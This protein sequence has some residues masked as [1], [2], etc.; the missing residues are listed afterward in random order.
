MSLTPKEQQLKVDLIKEELSLVKRLKQLDKQ[1][2]TGSKEFLKTAQQKNKVQADLNKLLGITQTGIKKIGKEEDDLLKKSKQLNSLFNGLDTSLDNVAKK[3][4]LAAS[5]QKAFAAFAKQTGQNYIKQKS[6]QE[7]ISTIENVKLNLT[8]Q[9][10]DAANTLLKSYNIEASILEES[11]QLTADIADEAQQLYKY[12]QKNSTTLAESLNTSYAKERLADMEVQFA[13]NKNKL[14]GKSLLMAQQ[15]INEARTKVGMLDEQSNALDYQ[16]SQRQAMHDALVG[17]FEA[18]KSTIES[19][20]GGQ[21]LSKAI[22]LDLFGD[23]LSEQLNLS[24]QTGL[25]EGAAAGVQRFKDLTAS[26]KVFGMSLKS[27]L[28]PLAAAGVLL[29]ALMLFKQMSAETEE[30]AANTGQSANQ[31][32]KMLQSARAMQASSA[33]NL[34]NTEEIVSAM[35]AMKEEFGSTANFS[36]ETAMNVANMSAAFGIAVGDAAA[37]QRQFEAMGQTS[38]EAF[39]TQALAANLSEAAGVA[40]G[41]VMKD[42]A[43]NSKRAAKYMGGNAKALTKAAIEAAR[44]GMELGDMVDIADG[45]LDI[46]SSIE[47]EFEASVMLGKQIN[48]DLARQL[49]LQGDIEGATKA[50]L[51]QVGSIHDFNKLDVLQRKKLAQAAGM[52]VGQLQDALQKQ[53]QMNSLTAEQKKR[54]DDASKAL[55]GGT[56][57]GEQLVKQQ[58]AALA[59]KEM[60]A[61][62]DKI[63]NTLMKALYPVIKAITQI[64]TNVLA[65]IL[66]VVGAIFSG[67]M[68]ALKPVLLVFQGIAKVVK[69]LSPALK[70]IAGIIG[71]IYAVKALIWAGDKA[72]LAIQ[73]T[74]Q[75]FSSKEQM[76]STATN[77]AKKMGLITDK[78]AVAQQKIASM[79]SKDYISDETMA[80]TLKNKGLLAKMK[81]NFQMGLITLKQKLGIGLSATEQGMLAT[82]LG[83]KGTEAQI[84]NQINASKNTGLMHTLKEI[85]YQAALAIK[86]GAVWTWEM[87]TNAEKRTAFLL[88]LKETVQ[89]GLLAIAKGAVWLWQTMTATAATATTAATG[90]GAAASAAAIAPT[91]ALA[92]T[93]AAAATAAMTTSSAASFG[94]GIA[95]ILAAVGIGVAA[96]FALMAGASAMMSDGVIGPSSGGSGGYGSRVLFG[97]EGAISFNN[98]DTIVAGTDL[99]KAND[100]AFGP[101]GSMSMADSGPQEIELK[102]IQKDAARKLLKIQMIGSSPM[103]ML[104]GGLG[105]MGGALGSMFGGGEDGES[106]EGSPV[107]D[108]TNATKLDALAAKLDAVITAIAGTGGSGGAQGPVQIVIGNKVIEEISGMMNVNKSY[109]IGAGNAGEES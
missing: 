33:N 103:G 74:R 42:I 13:A 91:A 4:N 5:N 46:E 56:L 86:K 36:N 96:L 98:K 3:G 90:A 47:A 18:M 85:G 88:T 71:G 92:T 1:G 62:F 79:Y 70:V 108:E 95:P 2:A 54:Y 68:F 6:V 38:Q 23:K 35:T 89:Q 78:Q 10:A 9:R 76:Y 26:T 20:P 104:M 55:E 73:K 12:T 51:D 31:A 102:D 48:M 67:F 87:M 19:F 83:L 44:L 27:A 63:K 28:L 64:F 77:L 21:F 45:L 49:A 101:E 57:T 24:L 43:Q 105:A 15:E 97:P 58:E 61:Q 100:A 99:F 75:F 34:A 41:K 81:E 94:V 16:I 30:L 66:D 8:G 25:N 50:V 60:S 65:P 53:E 39:N 72:N 69:F 93:H 59:A 84:E 109:Q 29:G 40:P 32:E 7:R 14:T 52:E 22:G 82:K 106:E 17:P 80:T 11:A 107:F 37:V